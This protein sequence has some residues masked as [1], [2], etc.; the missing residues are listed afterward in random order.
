MFKVK[1]KDK[2]KDISSSK[3]IFVNIATAMLWA[4]IAW[5]FGHQAAAE[6]AY[7]PVLPQFGGSNGQALQVLQ[8][9]LQ[10]QSAAD[11]KIK[12]AALALKKAMEPARKPITSTDRLIS[13]I[14]AAMQAR[15]A[16]NY[17]ELIFADGDTG[18][19]K[20]IK[21]GDTVI[22]YDRDSQEG[23][24]TIVIAPPGVLPTTFSLAIDGG[25]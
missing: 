12:A 24:L 8:Y 4:T 22:S 1:D 25:L 3:G 20:E 2:D 21:V 6:I 18:G 14:E 11:A 7:S 13:S 9:D 17:A 10:L 16:N 5:S 15:L 23:Q 19:A